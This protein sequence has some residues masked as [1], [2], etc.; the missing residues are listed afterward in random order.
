MRQNIKIDS[1][2][3]QLNQLLKWIGLLETG[4]QTV[5]LLEEG[6]ILLNGIPVH[7]KRKKIYPGDIVT[8]DG[9]EFLIAQ[10]DS[11]NDEC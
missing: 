5:F 6:K 8:I 3:I 11:V 7:E 4:G 1:S 9:T 2:M 10:T